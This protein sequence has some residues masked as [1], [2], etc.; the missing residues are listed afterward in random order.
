MN[1]HN[2]KLVSSILEKYTDITISNYQN[3][4]NEIYFEF[5]G[6]TSNIINGISNLKEIILNQTK[7]FNKYDNFKPTLNTRI[8]Y[9]LKNQ[10]NVIFCKTCNKPILENIS[11]LAELKNVHNNIN[12]LPI[13]KSLSNINYQN[14]IYYKNNTQYFLTLKDLVEKTPNGFF[15]RLNPVG[16]K[17]EPNITPQ[18]KYLMDWINVQLPLLHDKKYS[19]SYKVYWIM[20]G[21]EQFPKCKYCGNIMNSLTNF[22]GIFYGFHKYCCNRCAQKDIETQLTIQNT[23]KMHFGENVKTS[24]QIK[25][26]REK[27]KQ[28]NLLKYGNENAGASTIIQK[29]IKKRYIYNNIYFHSAPELAFYIYLKD[30]NIDFQYH[31]NEY[32][33]YIFNGNKHRYYPDFK[34]NGQFIEIKGD[35]FFDKNG[36]MKA[37]FKSHFK[38]DNEYEIAC[39]QYETKYKCMLDNNVKI[40][41]NIDYQKYIDYIDKKYGKNYLKQFKTI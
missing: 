20:Y 14:N 38:T 3:I 39:K 29:K 37:P 35:Q 8:A 5:K 22:I 28:T 40:L 30:N 9:C 19:I 26:I 17:L 4:L 41:R 7:F 23:L 11:I 31:S 36:K 13:I 1:I 32:F 2:K 12:C 6:N 33:E 10:F 25:Q 16:R 27:I 18:Y 24:L 15:N 34:I 21:I